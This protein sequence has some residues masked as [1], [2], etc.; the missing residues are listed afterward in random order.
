MRLAGGVDELG[1][2]GSKSV[3]LPWETIVAYRP[4]V[5]LISCCGFTIE[6]TLEEVSV[7]GAV[8]G[9]E[10][11]P[12]VRDGRVWVVDGSSYFSRPGPR[13][14]DSLELLAHVI[15]PETFDLPS[16]VQ[17]PVQMR[18]ARPPSAAR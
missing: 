4:E 10:E 7:L 16:W 13:L 11:I 5:V 12:A 8:K 18:R 17:S 15:H 3:T 9:W 2:E 1:R 14:V 6:R